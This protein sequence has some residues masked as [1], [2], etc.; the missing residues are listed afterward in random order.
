MAV[1][2]DFGDERERQHGT[3]Y[4]SEGI[5]ES[6]IDSLSQNPEAEGDGAEAP[7]FRYKS[8][9]DDPRQVGSSL[10]VG[11]RACRRSSFSEATS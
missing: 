3:E 8:K 6:L 4:L 9:L 10:G 11:G 7:S 1:F 5:T 2:T